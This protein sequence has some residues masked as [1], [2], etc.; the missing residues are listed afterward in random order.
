[1]LY[2]PQ[3]GTVFEEAFQ[4]NPKS[5]FLMTQLGGEISSQANRIRRII[6]LID[7]N[8]A[9]T[10]RDFLDKIWRQILSV[11]MGI[12]IL[13]PNMEVTTVGNIFYELGLLDSLGKE[14]LIIKTIDFKIPSDFVRTVYISYR[15][16][17][18]SKLT[19]FL[20]SVFE[21]ENHYS[22]MADLLI[23]DPVVSIDYL[24]RAYLISGNDDYKAKARE[25]YQNNHDVF[26]NI[27]GFH[28]LNFLNSH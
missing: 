8:S 9:V 20:N 23:A 22:T 15:R 3:T 10:G 7:A 14:S 5:C 18:A 11:P 28:I 25:I 6:R 4:Y 27:N 12:A 21:R 1:M 24:R 2:S 26:E 13:C 16:G 17:W 19:Q